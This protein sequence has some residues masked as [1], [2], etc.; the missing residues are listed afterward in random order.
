MIHNNPTLGIADSV[1]TDIL[2]PHPLN[3]VFIDG[4]L[5]ADLWPQ[6]FGR[7]ERFGPEYRDLITVQ[8]VGDPTDVREVNVSVLLGNPAGYH[9]TNVQGVNIIVGV[10]GVIEPAS[11]EWVNWVIN[12]PGFIT[13]GK[14]EFK[15]FGGRR[16]SLK[17]TKV[18]NGNAVIGV[19][20]L[21]RVLPGAMVNDEQQES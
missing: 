13:G 12:Q 4:D 8:L 2:T 16:F 15:T 17:S 1:I 19:Q 11:R 7:T 5:V 21:L 3:F 9:L 14:T 6:R 10:A 18:R 20:V